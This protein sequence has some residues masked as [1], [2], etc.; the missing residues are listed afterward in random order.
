MKPLRYNAMRCEA[1]TTFRWQLEYRS[2]RENGVISDFRETRIFII[3]FIKKI[4]IINF[5]YFPER[6][7]SLCSWIDYRHGQSACSGA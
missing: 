2:L 1:T 3:F 4:G 7:E 5:A 6:Y